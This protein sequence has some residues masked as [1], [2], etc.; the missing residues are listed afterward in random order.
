MARRELDRPGVGLEGLHEHAPRR[1]A[2]AAARELRQQLERALVGAEVGDAEAGIRVDHRGERN[3][4]EVVPLRDHLRAEQHGSIG[5]GEIAQRR[6]QGLRLLRRVGVEADR[7]QLGQ[8]P[9]QLALEPLRAGA[10]P[11]EVDRAAGRAFGG[12]RLGVAAVVAAQAIVSVQD[13]RD[14]ALR[15]PDRRAAGAA[16][17]RRRDTAPVQE[18]DRLAAALGDRPELRQQRPGERIAGLASEVDDPD[19]RQ[20]SSE[21]AAELEPLEPLPAFGARRRAAVDRDSTLERGPLRGDRAR[22]VAGVR[23]LLV[24]RVVLLVDADDADVAHRREDGRARADDDARLLGRDPLA[25]VTSLGIREPRV[26]ERDRVAE[27]G[28]E[29]A[30]RLRRQRDLR[31]QHDRRPPARDRRGARSQVDLG[32]AAAGLAVEQEMAAPLLVEGLLDPPER[33]PL[34]LR[35]LGHSLL[36]REALALARR[37]LLLAPLPLDGRDQL[38]RAARR[39][40]VVVGDPEREVDERGRQL[41]D[42]GLDRD[43]MDPLRGLVHDLDDDPA[44]PRAAERDRDDRTLLRPVR[45]LVGERPRQRARRHERVDG[46]VAAHAAQA[47]RVWR[48]AARCRVAMVGCVAPDPPKR[49]PRRG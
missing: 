24:G 31:H 14:V 13:E 18:Q 19:R 37:R 48:N 12:C 17:Q 25:L 28:A 43:R 16:V 20:R 33:G 47:R 26:Q 44:L 38:E 49:R 34:R 45:Q 35:Q 8:L 46:R 6:S 32:L 30:Q 42:D 4:G 9:C 41:V 21:P 5:G 7:D 1:V 40:A 11:G 29:T 10:D 3:A 2:A 27:A 23:L 36:E 39:R 15:T 22:V